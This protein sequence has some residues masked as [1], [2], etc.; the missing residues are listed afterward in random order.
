MY[1][2]PGKDDKQHASPVGSITR[3]NGAP[4]SPGNFSDITV[5]RED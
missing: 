2:V 4:W 1:Y 5:M 3:F